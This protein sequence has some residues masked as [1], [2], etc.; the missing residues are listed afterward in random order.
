MRLVLGHKD[1]TKALE[2]VGED[3]GRSRV[4]GTPLVRSVW[5]RGQIKHNSEGCMRW[6]SRGDGRIVPIPP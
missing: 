5:Q 3:Q 1:R 2:G 4:Y 6:A